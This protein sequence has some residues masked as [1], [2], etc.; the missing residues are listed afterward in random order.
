MLLNEK[1]IIFFCCRLSSVVCCLLFVS[2]L[3]FSIN[4]FSQPDATS[5]KNKYPVKVIAHRGASGHAPENTLA[6]F[7]K[8][9]EL[10]ANYI[11]LDV[12][13]SKDGDVVVIH[14]ATLDR[15]TNGTGNVNEKIAAE[16][17]QLNASKQYSE[18]YP[19]EKIPL[20][21]EVLQ[22]TKGKAILLIEIKAD[23]HGKPYRD[24]ERMIFEIIKNNHAE[25]W[26]EVQ[27]FY[28]F[29]VVSWLQLK[30]DIPV[31]KLL[32]GRIR[33]YYIDHKIKAGNVLKKYSD[34]NGINP[35]K[36]FAKRKFIR[37]IQKQSHISYVWTVNE[38][39]D[40]QKILR[41]NPNGIITN[42]PDRL[43]KILA[44]EPYF[45]KPC[46]TRF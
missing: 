16:L 31:H 7:R 20:L 27:S 38:E 13:L 28:D 42:Y 6:A 12:H 1:G 26:C 3:L 35:Y 17:Q 19:D 34:V 4:L 43:L 11:E 29:S 30:S 36:A 23:V 41:R 2:F 5:I 25:T 39:K 15:T 8:A 21:E 46:L 40:L 24:M 9:I 10:G 44:K 18:K 14:D 32:V 45:C 37:S 22:L 33:P